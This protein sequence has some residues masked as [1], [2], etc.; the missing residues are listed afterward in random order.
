MV[1]EPVNSTL[2]SA[3]GYNPEEGMLYIQFTSGAS[4]A[5]TA[6]GRIKTCN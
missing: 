6:D 2:I 3:A 5:Y 1:L 4:V